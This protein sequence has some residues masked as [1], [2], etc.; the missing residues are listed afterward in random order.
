MS[1]ALAIALAVVITVLVVRPD[2]ESRSADGGSGITAS[3]FASAND[4]GPVSIITEDPTCDAWN[5]VVGQYSEAA[6]GVNWEGREAET[7]ASSWTPE[8]RRMYQAV[9]M[10]MTRATEQVTKL[11]MQTPHRVMRELYEQFVAYTV[12][13]VERIPAYV[14][15][16]NNLA[17]A[18]N[19]A[20]SS[21]SNICGAI[22][23]RSAQALAILVPNSSS[24][25]AQT[26]LK[27]S[28]SK[29]F[30]SQPNSICQAWASE[31]E[32]FSEGTTEWRKID[33][34]IPASG[35]T[36]EQ[37]AVHDEVAPLMSANA[38]TME[39]LGRKSGD[40]LLEDFATLATQY[41]RA[42][43]L[44]LPRYSSADSYLALAATNLVRLISSACKAAS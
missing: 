26:G 7:P 31:V 23:F 42:F 10:A 20:G 12:A 37:R 43:V 19:A 32:V 6:T 13:F 44:S 41:R 40:P 39:E 5:T 3:E 27:T 34:N 16:D 29:P 17:L 28:T 25:S 38:D 21:V 9:G 15:E 33:K 4:T 22:T 24:P 1:V 11:A 14:A 18:S 8:Q 2:G 36:P 30:M 35:W